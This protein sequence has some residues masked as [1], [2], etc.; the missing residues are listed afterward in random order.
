ALID[1][2]R[3]TL[4]FG[5]PAAIVMIGV[6]NFIEG[7]G[8]VAAVLRELIAALCPDSY[9]AVVQAAPAERWLAAQRRWNQ[10]APLP[11]WLRDREEVASWF[12]GLSLVTPGIVEVQQWRPDQGDPSYPNG[13]PLHG[14]VGRKS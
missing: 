13:I 1:A 4:D 14:A 2:A 3:R 12:A 10:L 8:L 5:Q 9:L 6:L 11:V 7:P